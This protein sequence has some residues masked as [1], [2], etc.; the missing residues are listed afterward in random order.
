VLALVHMLERDVSFCPLLFAGEQVRWGDPIGFSA[1]GC[2]DNKC[3]RFPYRGGRPILLAT[4]HVLQRLQDAPIV[5]FSHQDSHNKTLCHHLYQ[6]SIL[7]A[8]PLVKVVERFFLDTRLSLFFRWLGFNFAGIF[9]G[10]RNPGEVRVTAPF[11]AAFA[12]ATGM[13]GTPITV[14]SRFLVGWGFGSSALE[15]DPRNDLRLLVVSAADSVDSAAGPLVRLLA[16]PR[17]G[18]FRRIFFSKVSDSFF[19]SD[20][21]GVIFPFP[22]LMDGLDIR[23]AL[24]APALDPATFLPGFIIVNELLMNFLLTDFLYAPV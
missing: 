19:Q 9:A 4:D 7:V 5:C 16:L 17:L 6:F 24:F 15:S 1:Y 10:R 21:F 3:F 12:A 20:L 8:I 11:A 13:T 18:N 23:R 22:Y 14:E 2:S